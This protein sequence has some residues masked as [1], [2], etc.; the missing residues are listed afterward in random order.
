MTN[1]YTGFSPSWLYPPADKV[2]L[3]AAGGHTGDIHY[4]DIFLAVCVSPP[5]KEILL[6]HGR[7]CCKEL[8]H[9]GLNCV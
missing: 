9:Y 4:I 8:Q 7:G 3:F 6:Q 2:D 1:W 5:A